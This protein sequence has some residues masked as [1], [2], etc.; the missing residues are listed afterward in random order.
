MSDSI[1]GIELKNSQIASTFIFC[2][3]LP[4]D[5][6]EQNY[7]EVLAKL[8]TLAP[9]YITQANIVIAGDLNVLYIKH[10]SRISNNKSKHLKPLSH[11][12]ATV[13]RQLATDIASG[14]QSSLET[15][16]SDS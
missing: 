9:H 12:T 1:L 8:Q 13:L 5:G 10:G 4:A 15:V 14:S 11:W 3:Y 6:N 7:T 2:V 16:A